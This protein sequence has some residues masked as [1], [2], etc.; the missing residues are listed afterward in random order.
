MKKCIWGMGLVTVVGLAGCTAQSLADKRSPGARETVE[1]VTVAPD[2][3]TS[4][5]MRAAPPLIGK[6]S[7]KSMW[8][9]SSC[10]A[11]AWK[12]QGQVETVLLAK[13]QSIQLSGDDNGLI[14]LADIQPLKRGS[15]VKIY[16]SD[17]KPDDA[18][19]DVLS[20]I[21]PCL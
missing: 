11:R 19:D 5:Q 9:V 21:Q 15:T 4:A 1:V 2:R 6:T 18:P 14:G 8:R 16:K 10:V 12:K 7:K 17:G 13:G 20:R 3:I